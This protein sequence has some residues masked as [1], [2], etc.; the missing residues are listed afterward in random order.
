MLNQSFNSDGSLVHG[1]AI[2]TLLW[3]GL[4]ALIGIGIYFLVKV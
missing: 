2:P 1:G 4:I 3:G